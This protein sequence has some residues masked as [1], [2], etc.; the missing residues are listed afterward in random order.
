MGRS[1]NPEHLDLPIGLYANKD[2]GSATGY[3]FYYKNPFFGVE[4]IP[5]NTKARLALGTDKA[6]AV[7]KAEEIKNA[8]S[9]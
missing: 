7:K 1:R 3:Y 5:N 6:K 2:K 4:G 8:Y 9:V